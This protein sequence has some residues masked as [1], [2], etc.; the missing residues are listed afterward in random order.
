MIQ[1]NELFEDSMD[2]VV[3]VVIAVPVN[4]DVSNSIRRRLRKVIE[5]LTVD[6]RPHVQSSLHRI[7]LFLINALV[8]SLGS[9]VSIDGDDHFLA[10]YKLVCPTKC[11]IEKKPIIAERSGGRGRRAR[12][13]RSA[14]TASTG[15][16]SHVPLCDRSQPYATNVAS[17]LAG[18][19]GGSS[20][21]GATSEKRRRQ[22]A[23][24]TEFSRVA[25]RPAPARRRLTPAAPPPGRLK[26]KYHFP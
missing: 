6:Y 17:R 20:V 23:T 18:A 26:E 7:S 9:R 25:P 16:I 4:A 3:I 13:S 21:C 19:A 12:A 14:P 11:Y 2:G 10:A 22:I 15:L 8:T 5:G 24:R 1:Q